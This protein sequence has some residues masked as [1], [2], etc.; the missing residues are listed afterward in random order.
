[1]SNQKTNKPSNM[2]MLYCLNKGVT[3][4]HGARFM[5]SSVLS[6]MFREII[7]KIPRIWSD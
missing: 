2:I 3:L 5:T 6:I 7:S 1:M 4:L